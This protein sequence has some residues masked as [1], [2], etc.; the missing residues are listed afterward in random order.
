[1]IEQQTNMTEA[2]RLKLISDMIARAKNSFHES[3]LGPILWGIV[4]AVCSL[5][6][7][8]EIHFQFKMAFDIWFLT[9]LAIV[10]QI[11]LVSR[12]KRKQK[13]RSRDELFMDA[14]WTVFGIS[15]FLLIFIH[16]HTFQHMGPAVKA[17]RA[18]VPDAKSFSDFS[19]SYFLLLYGIPTLITGVAKSYRPMFI[20]GIACWILAAASVY[21]PL[22]IDM[23][24]SALAA[25]LAWLIPGILLRLAYLKNRTAHV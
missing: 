7:F 2:E 8:A 10:P 20:G 15:I 21:T 25:T 18:T 19:T 1:M 12:E 3:G 22:K 23:L 14:V 6:T 11:I 9:L 17:L 16:Q 5:F 4:I 24:F 13:A